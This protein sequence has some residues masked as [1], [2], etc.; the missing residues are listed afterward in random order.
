MQENSTNF[1]LKVECLMFKGTKNSHRS[2]C[3]FVLEGL[4]DISGGVAAVEADV[5]RY[6]I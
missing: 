6:A 3:F 1:Q 4:R 5:G 2:D